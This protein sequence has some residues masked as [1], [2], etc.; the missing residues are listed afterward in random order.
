MY[1]FF[2]EDENAAEDFV[3]IEGSDVNH[4]KNVLRMKPGEKIRVCTRNG[5]NYFCSISD[6][7]ESFV[8]ADILE[9]AAH[10]VLLDKVRLPFT[11]IPRFDHAGSL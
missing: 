2:I 1:Q 5:Q 7:T 4:I 9:T 3:T 11:H 8:R 6:I 10:D